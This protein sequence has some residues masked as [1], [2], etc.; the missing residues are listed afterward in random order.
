MSHHRVPITAYGAPAAVGPF[1]VQAVT[2]PC[3]DDGM[4]LT[5][6]DHQH[7]AGELA[8]ASEHLLP[9]PPS[10]IVAAR[11][12]RQ[13]QHAGIAAAGFIVTD[14]FNEEAE[15]GFAHEEIS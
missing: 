11:A 6:V 10:E 9:D 13:R 3:V 2:A 14:R 7:A 8:G 15:R 12:R 5:T 1:A 4:L